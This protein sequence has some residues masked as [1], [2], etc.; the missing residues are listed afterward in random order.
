M[1]SILKREK[2]DKKGMKCIERQQLCVG[3]R[4]NGRNR[5]IGKTRGRRGGR[6]LEEGVVRDPVLQ[7]PETVQ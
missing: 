2:Q 1:M 5:K 7:L 3:G 4:G 6:G